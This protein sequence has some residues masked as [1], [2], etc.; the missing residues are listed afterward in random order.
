[1]VNRRIVTAEV[2]CITSEDHPQPAR[3]V[4]EVVQHT[5]NLDTGR[6]LERAARIHCRYREL[7]SEE[8]LQGCER[9][10]GGNLEH[11]VVG[12]LRVAGQLILREAAARDELQ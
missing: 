12:E 4:V 2:R 6:V 11:R 8:I 7:T 9:N 1:D 3:V 5:G 10:A